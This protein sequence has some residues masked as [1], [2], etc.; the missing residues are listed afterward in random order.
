MPD[1]VRYRLLGWDQDTRIPGDDWKADL[2]Y[3]AAHLRQL[4]DRVKGQK[5]Y[6]GPLTMQDIEKVAAA[7]NGSGA[8]AEKYGKDA[9]RTLRNAAAGKSPLYFYER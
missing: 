7:Y 1:D 5:K 3:T 9:I 4:I 8:L 2:Y 6:Y